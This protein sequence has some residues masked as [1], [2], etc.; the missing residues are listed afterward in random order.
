MILMPE[1]FNVAAN[2]NA[3]YKRNEL[4]FCT[5]YFS[6]YSPGKR[7]STADSEQNVKTEEE[8]DQKK[9]KLD[10]EGSGKEES[11][12]YDNWDNVI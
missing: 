3:R 1:I 4:E 9:V 7:K 6:T 12:R 10:D 11:D 5:L 2:E 8:K